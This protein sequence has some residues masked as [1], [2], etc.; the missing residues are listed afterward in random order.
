MN[1]YGQKK[2]NLFTGMIGAVLGA[3]IGAAAWMLVARANIVSAYVGLLIALL[4]GYGYD[5]FRGPRP[6]SRSLC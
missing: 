4:S 3:A 2:T 1:T 6:T 5:L